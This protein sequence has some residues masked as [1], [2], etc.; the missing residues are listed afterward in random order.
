MNFSI[1][2][3]DYDTLSEKEENRKKSNFSFVIILR[4]KQE[5]N[6]RREKS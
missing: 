6:Q 5:V 2:F 4:G 1:Y 3:Q